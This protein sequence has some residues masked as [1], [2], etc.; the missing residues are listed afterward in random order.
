MRI[1]I[2]AF[3]LIIVALIGFSSCENK[4]AMKKVSLKTNNDSVAYIIG[5]NI[6]KQMKS[7]SLQ[8]DP[9]ILAA[10][11]HDALYAD[12]TQVPDELA[13]Q[14]MM[15]FQQNMQAKGQ[16]KMQEMQR[17]AQAEAPINKEKGE[18]F[19]AEN[20]TKPGVVTTASGLQ[21]KIIN[22]GNGRK[23]NDSSNVK[24]H[25]KGYTID[26]KIFDSS[27]ERKQPADMNVANLI[28][29]WREAMGMMKEGDK[30]QLFIP[31]NLAYGEQGP[32]QIGNNQTLI[33][34]VELIQIVDSKN[35]QSQG[36][37]PR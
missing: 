6:G 19:L 1:R 5:N 11:L 3:S 28:T 20:K 35:G 7:D 4:K 17:K 30:W 2:L 10:G 16:Q 26:G 14:T 37:M 24:V 32:P 31:S 27:Y 21:Y 22:A 9:N 36:M 23:A 34:E 29:G 25:Y 15:T 8:V 18:K 33:F 13:R 12:T